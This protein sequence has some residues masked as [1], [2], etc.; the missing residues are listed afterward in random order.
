MSSIIYLQN[1]GVLGATLQS[2]HPAASRCLEARLVTD[3]DESLASQ[4]PVFWKCFHLASKKLFLKFQPS[5]EYKVRGE[6]FFLFC[7]QI[8]IPRKQDWVKSCASLRT[9]SLTRAGIKVVTV[10]PGEEGQT[11]V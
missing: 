11:P 4:M 10:T 2:Q 9:N 5:C 3:L 1:G 6:G 8:S 7:F